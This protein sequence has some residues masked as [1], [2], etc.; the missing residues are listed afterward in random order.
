MLLR[1]ITRSS[2]RLVGAREDLR[3]RAASP[4][5]GARRSRTRSTN[6]QLSERVSWEEGSPPYYGRLALEIQ[7]SVPISAASKVPQ[8]PTQVTHH[9]DMDDDDEENGRQ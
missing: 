2:E 6:E 7:V 4:T 5:N 1:C 3:K 8:T 9:H